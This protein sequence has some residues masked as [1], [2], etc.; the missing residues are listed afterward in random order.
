MSYRVVA[1]FPSNVFP[2]FMAGSVLALLPDTHLEKNAP[3][4]QVLDS[5]S[6]SEMDF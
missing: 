3:V 2:Y 1:S 5:K 6:V 4:P